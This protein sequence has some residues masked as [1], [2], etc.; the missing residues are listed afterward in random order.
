MTHRQLHV[1]PV[2]LAYPPKE[3][4]SHVQ[5]VQT[6]QN[7]MPRHRDAAGRCAGH[8]GL[9]QGPTRDWR[10]GRVHGQARKPSFGERTLW[11]LKTPP[12]P[13]D[14]ELAL[15]ELARRGTEP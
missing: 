5:P 11:R 3:V 8:F 4:L 15:R 14:R 9:Q 13:L 7:A 12:M 10:S 1:K 6:C 2:S